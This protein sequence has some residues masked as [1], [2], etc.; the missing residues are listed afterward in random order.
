MPIEVEIQGTGQIAEFP[1][2]T[3]PEAIKAALSKYRS[4]PSGLPSASPSISNEVAQ[5]S[6]QTVGSSNPVPS[7]SVDGF[8][9]VSGVKN[10]ALEF[11]D[12]LNS[13]GK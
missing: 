11:M 5:P 12:L 10:A 6:N 7:D 8:D 9:P 13:P 2:G 4:Q 1:D 3:P